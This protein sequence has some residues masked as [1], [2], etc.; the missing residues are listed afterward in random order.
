[1]ITEKAYNKLTF[2]EIV[3]GLPPEREKPAGVS[4]ALPE[5]ALDNSGP[6]E[7]GVKKTAK[8]NGV[9]G[10]KTNESEKFLIRRS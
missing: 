5:A 6:R 3:A 7:K 2:S 4:G 1:L 9:K 8:R 10:L